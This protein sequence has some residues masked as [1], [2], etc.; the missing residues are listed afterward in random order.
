MRASDGKHER[1]SRPNPARPHRGALGEGGAL[2]QDRVH[3]WGLQGTPGFPQH[4][5]ASSVQPRTLY[6]WSRPCSV[7][8]WLQRS[9]SNCGLGPT[10]WVV[11]PFQV[12]PPFTPTCPVSL[13]M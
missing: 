9:F 12:G 7:V 8:Q 1:L 10:R 3:L 11:S 4:S 6:L 2:A 5:Q 13:N